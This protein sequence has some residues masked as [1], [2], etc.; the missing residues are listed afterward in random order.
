[1]EDQLRSRYYRD[2]LAGYT[3]PALDDLGASSSPGFADRGTTTPPASLSG[4]FTIARRSSGY[5][6]GSSN[7]IAR[8]SARALAVWQPG[9]LLYPAAKRTL[10]VTVSSIGL[11]LL[12]PVFLLIALLIWAEDGG[13]VF[14]V[15]NRV[16]RNGRL[17][18]FYKFRSMVPNADA[19]KEKL[20]AL[21]EATGPVFKIRHDPR[22]TRIGRILRKTS[23]DELP[24]LWNVLRGDMSL[25]GPRP[26][27]PS[28]VARYREDQRVRLSVAPGLICL[29]EVTGRSNLTFE[30]WIETDLLYIQSRSLSTDLKILWRAIPAILK[31]DGA[32]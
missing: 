19:L 17:F 25:V 32:Y 7:R 4:A 6:G 8:S 30:R 12:A 13:T 16:G 23:L 5:S 28:E 18:P 24:Q 21:N 29:R 1:L 15:H 9:I 14:Y 11:V 27:L 10:D 26:H 2:P 20:A 22:I 3:D 31:G